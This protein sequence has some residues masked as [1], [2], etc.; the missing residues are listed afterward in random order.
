MVLLADIKGPWLR[1]SRYLPKVP[2]Q[3]T[4]LRYLPRILTIR[5]IVAGARGRGRRRGEPVIAVP[6]LIHPGTHGSVAS[7]AAAGRIHAGAGSRRLRV[8]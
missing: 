6:G 5:S 7:V 2:T 4:Y 8:V 3:G 1:P